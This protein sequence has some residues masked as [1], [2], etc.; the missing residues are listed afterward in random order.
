MAADNGEGFR[1]K[2]AAKGGNPRT[3]QSDFLGQG[4]RAI[5][6]SRNILGTE[7]KDTET[8]KRIDRASD[9]LPNAPRAGLRVLLRKVVRWAGT[10]SKEPMKA[11]LFA[12][13]FC[14]VAIAFAGGSAKMNLKSEKLQ[15][16]FEVS[17]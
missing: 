14:L 17:R 11:L 3:D 16:D 5:I 9:T 1:E 2:Q 15:L 6:F 12:I 8:A 10:H 4:S 13:A 7:R